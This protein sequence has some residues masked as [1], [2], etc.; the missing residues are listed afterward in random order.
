[1]PSGTVGSGAGLA[2]GAP[3]E[4]PCAQAGSSG[5]LSFGPELLEDVPIVSQLNLP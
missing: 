2:G 1:M 3:G 4:A 5:D